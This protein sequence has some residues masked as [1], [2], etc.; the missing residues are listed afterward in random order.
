MRARDSGAR[1]RKSTRLNSSHSQISYAVF[2]LKKK[3]KNT[4]ATI[5]DGKLNGPYTCGT[6]HSGHPITSTHSLVDRCHAATAIGTIEELA[7]TV[8]TSVTHRS[9]VCRV[10]AHVAMEMAV[11]VVVLLLP[12]ALA[13]VSFDV[14]NFAISWLFI[15][16]LPSLSTFLFFFFFFNDPPPPEISPF[17]LHDALPIPNAITATAARASS[18]AGSRALSAASR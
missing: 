14:S 17:P 1:D 5:S 16:L 13:T 9:R 7:A 4:P 8:T 15:S 18:V 2:C 10:M 3:N 11:S 12:L 6:N